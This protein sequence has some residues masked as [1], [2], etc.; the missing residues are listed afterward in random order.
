MA[1]GLILVPIVSLFTQKTLPSNVDDK[2]SC[3]DVQVVTNQND[4]LG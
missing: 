2:F 1:G 4:S 3:Y